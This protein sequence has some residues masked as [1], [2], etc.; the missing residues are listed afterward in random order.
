MQSNDW[1]NGGFGLYVHWPFCAAKCPYCDFNSHVAA[2]VNHDDWAQAFVQEIRRFGVLSKHRRLDSIYFGGGTPSLM[3]PKTMELVIDEAQ[4]HWIFANNIEITFEANPT[5]VEIQKFV[6]FRQAGANRVSLGVQALNDADLSRLGR[7]HSAAE[8][9]EAL[10]IAKNSFERVNVDLI[11]ARQD[12]DLASWENELKLALSFSPSHLS[13]YQLT[14]EEGTVFAKRHA[15][16]HLRGLP[17]E[18]Q[19]ADMYACTQALCEDAGLAAYEVSNHAKS[20]QESQ[21]N[22]IYWRYGDYLGIGPGA[23]GRL[24]LGGRKLALEN[25][26][27]PDAWLKSVRQS[28]MVHLFETELT[29]LDQI[30]EYLLMGLRLSEGCELRRF[31]G[32]VDT[33][34]DTPEMKGLIDGGFL[35]LKN[36][37]LRTTKTGRPLLNAILERIVPTG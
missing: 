11:Y 6:S 1:K 27:A 5:S 32:Q 15:A 13:L 19:E 14:I 7:Q 29:K 16:G 28:E 35:E 34:L 31:G 37:K 4:R 21:H 33:I 30:S 17:T 3:S 36:E 20:G 23:H 25:T 2:S 12:Q 26:S 9:L 24:T 22:L 10:E 8:A 18:T